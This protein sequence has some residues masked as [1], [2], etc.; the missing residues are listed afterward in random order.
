MP[1]ERTKKVKEARSA[2]MKSIN[3]KRRSEREARTAASVGKNIV[4]D[5][6]TG[7]LY[8][9]AKFSYHIGN[10]L[11]HR[12]EGYKHSRVAKRTRKDLRKDRKRRMS[13]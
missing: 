13:E 7:G 3:E 8:S 6:A 2:Q 9:K 4:Y 12:F 10:S 11:R 1:S 5:H